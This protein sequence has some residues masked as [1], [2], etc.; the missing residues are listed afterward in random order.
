ML[1][2]L[3]LDGDAERV[4]RTLLERPDAD[5]S[6]LADL[7]EMTEQ[8]TSAALSELADL[9]LVLWDAGNR[10]QPQLVDPGVA[11]QALVSHHEAQ[12]A[13]QT[14]QL[15]QSRLAISQILAVRDA[16]S[17]CGRDFGIE[18][19]DDLSAVREKLDELAGTCRE[20]VWSFNTGGPQSAENLARSRPANEET[21]QRG[22]R[23]RA[24][25]LDS[26]RNDPFS[27][28]HAEWL[29]GLGAAVRTTPTLPIRMLIVDRAT[30]VL[31][32]DDQDSSQGALVVSGRGMV[33]GLV[34]L[35]LSTW[36]AAVPLGP[37]VGRPE[38]EP[39]SAPERHALRLWAQG[40]TDAAVGRALGVSDRTVR[41]ISDS[42]AR[43]LGAH[44]RFEA[45]ARAV[46]TGW[47]TSDDL[48]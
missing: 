46:E 12:I 29:T 16:A 37:R 44:S 34:A 8:Q 24:I 42:L 25:Y 40:G 20:E 30:A 27:A 32:I 33:A 45:G 35:F 9:A 5:L 47:L 28:E 23:M 48:I 15:E 2:Q 36:K 17:R 10:A 18:R 3:G 22:V 13:A 1:R 14:H 11:L 4:Y 21:L 43:R 39:L 19:F 7:A 41:R 38:A 31:P 26:V 6:I